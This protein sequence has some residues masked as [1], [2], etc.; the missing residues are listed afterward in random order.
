MIH[1]CAETGISEEGR[2]PRK[3]NQRRKQRFQKKSKTARLKRIEN[4]AAADND[5]RNR[6]VRDS[7]EKTVSRPNKMK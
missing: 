4:R 5:I 6:L 7:P 2:N 1:L 3:E